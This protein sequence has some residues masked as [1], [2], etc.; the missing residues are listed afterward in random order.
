MNT[1]S[2]YGPRR[3]VNIRTPISHDSSSEADDLGDD[4]GEEFVQDS[5]SSSSSEDTADE[6]DDTLTPDNAVEDDDAAAAVV[7]ANAWGQVTA[8][9]RAHPL[10]GKEELLMQPTSTGS[11][12]SVTSLDAYALFCY[13]RYCLRYC[14]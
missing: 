7:E 4:S 10:T 8:Q 14:C 9:L 3:N 13:R 1:S 11:Q 5:D 2:F 6:N 12:G